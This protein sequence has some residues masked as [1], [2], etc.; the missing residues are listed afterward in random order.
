MTDARPFNLIDERWL[1]V[2]RRS[3]RRDQIAPVGITSDLDSDP[4]VA[5][6]WPRADFNGAALEFMVGLLSTAAPPLDEQ[7]WRAWWRQPPTPETLAE[8]FA[9][10]GDAFVLDGD[11]AR[12]LQDR[13]PLTDSPAKPPA[14]LLVETPGDQTLR[15]NT[16][17]FV[18]RGSV[19]HLGRASA[20]MALYTLQTYAPSG[21]AGHMTSLRGGGPLTTLIV[22]DTPGC[23]EALWGS[24]WP[25]VETQEQLSARADGN[26]DGPVFPWLA[27]TRISGK[28]GRK[29]TPADTHPL[30]VYWGMPRRIRLEFAANDDGTRC[31]VSGLAEPTVLTGYRTA[32]Y[33]TDYDGAAFAHP[34][35]PYHRQRA[36]TATLPVHANPGGL[37][38][39]HWAGIVVPTEDRLREPARVVSHWLGQRA[40]AAGDNRPPRVHAYGFDMD[41]MKARA[42]MEAEMR[43]WEIGDA[44]TAEWAALFVQRAVGAASYV[45]GLLV[46]AIKDSRQDRRKD[47]RGDYGFVSER[48]FRD[49]ESAFQAA[50]GDLLP[51]LDGG[52]PDADPLLAVLLRWRDALAA[53]ALGV[54]DEQSPSAELEYGNMRRHVAARS[55][56]S[57]ALRGY[58]KAGGKLH[59]L[60]N[61][62]P[63][64]RG[65]AAP[66]ERES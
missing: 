37:G 12:F 33:G 50:L 45:A 49:T 65:N 39:R 38:Y 61:L 16:D 2:R 11:G 17:V 24:L 10:V 3:G 53:C 20:A 43:L 62:P 35:S 60:L 29:T 15:N 64:T 51:T 54:F 34:L 7:A 66:A 6:D 41:N 32:T 4:V 27:P 52:A 28:N 9:S 31:P 58:R 25:N 40:G 8:R 1:P 30:Q 47:A 59:A 63:P 18:K 48:F 46:G 13:D 5:F 44:A 55:S 21:G 23:G 26:M 42:W 14:A 57:A 22:A 56:L 36:G 19:S